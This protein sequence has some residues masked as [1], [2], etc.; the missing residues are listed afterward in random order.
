MTCQKKE[1]NKGNSAIEFILVLPWLVGCLLILIQMAIWVTT[2]QLL[3]YAAFKQARSASVYEFAGGK[4]E[5]EAILPISLH[6]KIQALFIQK[7]LKGIETNLN[8]QGE[9]DDKYKI[10]QMDNFIGL[11]GDKGEYYLCDH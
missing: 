10:T 9:K 6:S 3:H 11:C 4:K 1:T 5:I 8:Q 2:A 7:A